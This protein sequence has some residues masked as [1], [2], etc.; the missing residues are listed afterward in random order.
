MIDYIDDN[1]FDI[2][3]SIGT[4]T[5][6]PL[7]DMAATTELIL[8]HFNQTALPGNT[9]LS[10]STNNTNDNDGK[11]LGGVGGDEFSG[12]SHDEELNSFYFYEVSKLN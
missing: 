9:S 3:M 8:T 11:A 10:L 4:T 2:D 5:K 7:G 1:S 12:G 6:I